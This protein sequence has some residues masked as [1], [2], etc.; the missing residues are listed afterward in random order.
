MGREISNRG[1]EISYFVRSPY[2]ALAGAFGAPGFAGEA[3][4]S[5]S[6]S[7]ALS[8]VTFEDS[9]VSRVRFSLAPGA[10]VPGGERGSVLVDGE[11]PSS[12]RS[13]IRDTSYGS[14]P[15]LGRV[16]VGVGRTPP[17]SFRVRDVIEGEV[18]S[19]TSVISGG[20]H[21]SSGD[22][23]VRQLD[24]YG[25]CMSTS[26]AVRCPTPSARWPVAFSGGRR[27]STST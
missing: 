24:G 10:F 16:S 21:R 11:G 4:S 7:N 2:S 22:H 13:S 23:N 14:S 8:A 17:R 3:G 26:R 1:G 12:S 20:G 18:V 5:Q 27:V 6:S 9:L 15:V 25:L 19:G